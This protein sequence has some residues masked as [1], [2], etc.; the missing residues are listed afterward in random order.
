MDRESVSI[1]SN[2]TKIELIQF[3][4]PQ[5]GDNHNNINNSKHKKSKKGHSFK[6]ERGYIIISRL[7]NNSNIDKLYRE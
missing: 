7:Y 3:P 5:N 2:I 4:D 1:N 6:K